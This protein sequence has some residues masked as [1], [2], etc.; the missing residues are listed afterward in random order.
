MFRTRRRASVRVWTRILEAPSELNGCS[1]DAGRH[2]GVVESA[3]CRFFGSVSGLGISPVSPC[4][5]QTFQ[6]CVAAALATDTQSPDRYI[7][8]HRAVSRNGVWQV[9][10]VFPKACR[11][12]NMQDTVACI[13]LRCFV[14]FELSL[15]ERSV[16]LGRVMLRTV[17]TWKPWAK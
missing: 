9:T 13:R 2:W 5:F 14:R 6:A 15:R 1:Y 4:D 7:L 17:N 16:G 8:S 3:R 12:R 10:S 11:R